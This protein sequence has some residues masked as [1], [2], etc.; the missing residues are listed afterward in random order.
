MR[1]TRHYAGSTVCAPSRS[2]LMTGRHAGHA[3]LRTNWDAPMPDATPTLASVLKAS[4]YTTGAFGKW[5]VGNIIPEYDPNRKGFDV[6]YGYVDMFHAHNLFPPFM[7]HNGRREPLRN[8]L[9]ADSDAGPFAGRGNGF[10]QTPVDYGPDLLIDRALRFIDANA[11]RPFF[12]YVPLNTPHANN[13]GGKGEF[14]RGMEVPDFGPFADRDWPIEEKGF[15]RMMRDLD[16]DVGR[17]VA[18]LRER[19]VGEKTLVIFTSDNGPHQEGGHQVDFFDSN[20]PLR[21]RKRDLYE[22]GIRVPTLA[23]WPGRVKAGSTSTHLSGFQDYMATFGE[24]AGA[25]APAGDGISFAAT[26]LGQ[27]AK[28]RRHEFLYW[29]FYE[30]G[31]KQ[32]VVTDRWKAVRL[33]WSAQP[34]GPLE[35]YDLETDPGEERN[36]ATGHPDVVRAM[37]ERMKAA[38]RPHTGATTPPY[39]FGGS[40]PKKS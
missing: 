20:G 31:G 15:A 7:V 8:G 19:G 25:K 4:G 30:S 2:V 13:E 24:L 5:G 3:P 12:L 21:G 35:L 17:I 34:E 9:V 1:F 22:G 16:R 26:L 32:A 33:N 23:W 37:R 18:K 27:E 28:Q 10:A 38:H 29:E 36:V 39:P 14:K 40:R 6:F 11:S